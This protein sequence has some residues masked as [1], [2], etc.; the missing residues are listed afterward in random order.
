MVMD[1]SG[2]AGELHAVLAPVRMSLVAND[3]VNKGYLYGTREN[4]SGSQLTAMKS[5]P[6]GR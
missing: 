4:V 1:S 3:L 6:I 5:K 2:P